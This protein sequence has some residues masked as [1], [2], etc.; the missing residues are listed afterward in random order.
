MA[1]MEDLMLMAGVLQLRCQSLPGRDLPQVTATAGGE[2]WAVARA[3][4]V[5]VAEIRDALCE[6][7]RSASRKSEGQGRKISLG[8]I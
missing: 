3:V 7:G 2:S 6:L 5:R 8:A 1:D 4:R